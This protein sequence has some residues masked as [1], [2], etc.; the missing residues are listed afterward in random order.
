MSLNES[1]ITEETFIPRSI[2][3]KNLLLPDKGKNKTE[4]INPAHFKLPKPNFDLQAKKKKSTM[5]S[6][7]KSDY[8]P[9]NSPKT[10]RKGTF[11]NMELNIPKL[12]LDSPQRKN[13]LELIPK[14]LNN[15]IGNNDNNYPRAC[16]GMSER[17][18][19]PNR[20][21]IGLKV[22][23]NLTGN[24]ESKTERSLQSS[25]AK[26]SHKLGFGKLRIDTENVGDFDSRMVQ[27]I[28]TTRG[29]NRHS[30]FSGGSG[31]R[32]QFQL[33]ETF[34]KEKTNAP[35]LFSEKYNIFGHKKLPV[36]RTLKS[37][38]QSSPRKSSASPIQPHREIPVRNEQ[39]ATT[40]LPKYHPQN[41]I[42]NMD[43]N[44]HFAKT[45]FTC[46]PNHTPTISTASN[47]MGHKLTPSE[48]FGH[49]VEDKFMNPEYEASPFNEPINEEDESERGE[50]GHHSRKE[51]TIIN[52]DGKI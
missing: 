48:D 29:M 47:S 7:K 43:A 51:T 38:I 34:T 45:P 20:A 19:S 31:D 11:E 8:S 22:M 32:Y 23:K 26:I 1:T 12:K 15:I 25:A 4:M 24:Y 46:K 13:T 10:K 33:T 6:N 52:N 28:A 17:V 18:R 42:A 41:I 40:T 3:S 16:G 30:T 35:E 36:L 37:D 5:G 49:R 27:A 14:S 21:E 2:A 44:E 9:F 39:R 50:R